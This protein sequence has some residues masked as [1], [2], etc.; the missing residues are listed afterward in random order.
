MKSY[1]KKGSIKALQFDRKEYVE[2]IQDEELMA[3]LGKEEQKLLQRVKKTPQGYF[4]S[5]SSG[6]RPISDTSWIC[7]DQGRVFT[8]SDKDFKGKFE[9]SL[10]AGD[11]VIANDELLDANQS[12]NEDL[13]LSQGARKELADKLTKV[14]DELEQKIVEFDKI[15]EAHKQLILEYAKLSDG[16]KGVKATEKAVVPKK[17]KKF[18]DK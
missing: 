14:S 10:N 13:E 2:L 9:E 5:S 6:L 1:R 17:E 11:K 12:L 7:E 4:C 18:A 15:E 8:M 16:L 3:E